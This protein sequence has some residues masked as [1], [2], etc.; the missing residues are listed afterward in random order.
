MCIIAHKK[1]T[2]EKS[3]H[4]L[5]STGQSFITILCH[6]RPLHNTNFQFSTTSKEYMADVQTNEVETTLTPPS[7]YNFHCTK[8]HN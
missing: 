4:M 6:G 8:S 7:T 1:N 3:N 2:K 5:K